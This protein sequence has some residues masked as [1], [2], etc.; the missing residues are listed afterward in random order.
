MPLLCGNT[1]KATASKLTARPCGL[2]KLQLAAG[3]GAKSFTH[4]TEMKDP[5]W[6]RPIGDDRLWRK[7]RE[8]SAY[9]G[10]A[11]EEYSPKDVEEEAKNLRDVMYGVRFPRTR[12]ERYFLRYMGGIREEP[13]PKKIKCKKCGAL[14]IAAGFPGANGGEPA[15]PTAC[16]LCIDELS[17]FGGHRWIPPKK[18]VRQVLND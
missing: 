4:L 9:N 11:P 7:N 6:N 17:A 18:I 8:G 14:F 16:Q 12:F 2:G 15:Y 3:S 10:E 1:G 5:E 13:P